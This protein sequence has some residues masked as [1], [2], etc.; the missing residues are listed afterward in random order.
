MARKRN[1]E[2][3]GLPARWVHKHGAYYYVPPP[4]VRSMWDD[5]TWFKLGDTLAEA[6]R[7]WATRMDRPEVTTLGNLFDRYLLEVIPEKKAITGNENRRQIEKLRPTFGAMN[8]ADLEPHHVYKYMDA[9]TAKVAAKREVETLSHVF[10]K[11]V[12]WGV[13]KAHPFKGEVRVTGLKK[14]RTR[15]VED[16]E[17][18][19]TLAMKPFRKKGSVLMIQSYLRLKLLTGLRQRDLLMLTVSDC[20]DDGIHVDPSKTRDSTGKRLVYEW[21]DQLR[22]AVE[23][24]KASRPALSPYLFCKTDGGCM[25]DAVTEKAKAFSDTWQNFMGRV[26]KETKVQLRFTE[27]DLRAKVGSDAESLERARQLLAHSDVRLTEKVYRRK[28]ERIAPAKGIGN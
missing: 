7:E 8:V 22:D 28:A 20:K 9:R 19:E 12:E 17:L 16:W 24:A 10:T 2:N 25:V 23:N 14:P 4:A 5:K 26:L 3:R 11:A 27:H 15:Y 13:I 21:T 6:Y 1:P 18:I